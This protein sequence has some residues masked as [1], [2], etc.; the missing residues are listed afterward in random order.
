MDRSIAARSA[1]RFTTK[2]A[3]RAT[4]LQRAFPGRFV[5]GQ[6]DD[7]FEGL[8]ITGATN[9]QRFL[10]VPSGHAAHRF[11]YIGD[12]DIL[13]LSPDVAAIHVRHARQLGLCYSNVV[14][15]NSRRLSGLHFV[16]SAVY[17]AIVDEGFIQDYCRTGL[18]R[19]RG[20]PSDEEI[21]YELCERAFQLPDHPEERVRN[22]RPVHG[23]HTSPH[24]QPL[25]EKANWGITPQRIEQYPR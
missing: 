17:Y 4:T 13:T 9:A 3:A 18:A 10:R 1:I 19:R 14:R 20:H 24:R 15:P 21:L 25:G 7:R 8:P 5:L 12:V 16:Y 22:F 11:V 6:L 23:I 2:F